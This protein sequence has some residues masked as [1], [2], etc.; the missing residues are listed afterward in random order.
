MIGGSD[1]DDWDD[2]DDDDCGG[3]GNSNSTAASW[4]FVGMMMI[5]NNDDNFSVFLPWFGVCCW[6]NVYDDG[7]QCQIINRYVGTVTDYVNFTASFFMGFTIFL[8]S[9]CRIIDCV[10]V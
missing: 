3:G 1:C 7:Y 10:K 5:M 6:C 8:I 2:Y 9:I 4:V